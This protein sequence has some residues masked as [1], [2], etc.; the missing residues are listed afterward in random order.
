MQSP[1]YALLIGAEFYFPNITPEGAMFESLQGC[2]RDIKRI[3]E[4]LLKGRLNVPDERILKL[5]ASYRG[6]DAQAPPEPREQWPTYDNIVKKF[7]ELRDMAQPGSQ[8][9]IHYSGHGG[10]TTTKYKET[11]GQDGVDETLAPIDIEDVAVS[12][13][14]RDIELA[15]LLRE[16]VA[17]DL[18]VTLVLDSCHSGGMTRGEGRDV[19]V[20]G[21]SQ[22]DK[23]VRE[24]DK[25]ESLVARHEQLIETW[26]GMEAAATRSAQVTSGWM[27]EAKGY[28]MLAACRENESAV[29]YAF[30][31]TD[32]SGALTYWLL[33]S[34]QDLGPHISWK[35]VHDR[36]LGKIN[37]QFV[38]QTPQVEGDVGR[39]V[40]GLD[41][42]PPAYAVNVL[43]YNAAQALVQLNTGQALG[44][45][46]HASFAIFP[47]GTTD[48]S[49]IDQHLALAEI[50]DLGASSSLAKITEGAN[51]LNLQG[52]E[53]AV[54]IDSGV[55]AVRGQVRLIEEPPPPP[56]AERAAALQAIADAIV[57]HGRGFLTQVGKDQTANYQVAI[58]KN[59]EYEILDAQGIAFK[60]ILPAVKIT[61]AGAAEKVV[62]RLRHLYKFHTIEQLKNA[63]V[64][65]ML[66]GQ[67]V[68]EAFKAPPG[69]ESF[70]PPP[71]NVPLEP[72]DNVGGMMIVKP[73]DNVYIHIKNNS[74][75][76]LN[77][78]MLDLD[79]DWSV[80]QN[81]PPKQFNK[82]TFLLE[83]KKDL[84]PILTMGFPRAGYTEGREI[85]KVLATIGPAS[86]RFLELP[87]LDEQSQSLRST[88]RQAQGALEQLLSDFNDDTH[89]TRSAALEMSASAQWAVNEVTL[90]L[91]A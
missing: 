29:E 4:E 31:G 55:V 20:R 76:D 59:G 68:V 60:N 37:S 74:Q 17:K 71:K 75:L 53:P 46:K 91:R 89:K 86:F 39:S 87:S 35:Q 22:I 38:R 23:R 49:K 80:K 81:I 34:L 5:M 8:V 21:T 16:M 40:L 13:Y 28:V 41:R 72:L 85:L 56:A 30:N 47:T 64:F 11:K 2:V 78:A 79:S 62:M 70:V 19:A 58:S 84:W 15:R 61:D 69:A 6:K 67:L 43:Q 52:G 7:Q 90:H 27:P 42:I 36:I 26:E 77:I 25:E 3:E 48:F 82:D 18:V 65:S 63:D 9:Y 24:R 54:M 66:A 32:R 83:S 33:H 73:G 12:R 14:V 44:A 10:R 1:I 50:T 45:A 57:Q 88:G 51:G